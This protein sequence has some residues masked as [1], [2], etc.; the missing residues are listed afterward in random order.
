MLVGS[1]VIVSSLVGF[2]VLSMIILV[3]SSMFDSIINSTSSVVR[4]GF[5]VSLVR[6]LRCFSAFAEGLSFVGGFA[7]SMG[8]LDLIFSGSVFWC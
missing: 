5:L 7:A 1:S 4:I 6:L 3:C 8:G 2:A